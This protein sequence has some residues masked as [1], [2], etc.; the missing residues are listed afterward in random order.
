MGITQ[1]LGQSVLE[2]C[3]VW[4]IHELFLV[5]RW[6]PQSRLCS[7]YPLP[8]SL[9]PTLQANPGFLVDIASVSPEAK[10]SGSS[11]SSRLAMHTVQAE[12]IAVGGGGSAA[13]EVA[14]L[15]KEYEALEK[16]LEEVSNEAARLQV[17]MSYVPFLGSDAICLSTQPVLPTIRALLYAANIYHGFSTGDRDPMAHSPWCTSGPT[18]FGA[19]R[20]PTCKV[21][22]NDM[23]PCITAIY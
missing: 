12:A 22:L 7:S 4:D 5:R 15:K 14:K 3:H 11:A 20:A 13:V 6:R 17:W 10:D 16:Q 19:P 18:S 1:G 23:R 2:S 9:L 8:T 21:L